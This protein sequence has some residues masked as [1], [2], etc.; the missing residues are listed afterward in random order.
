MSDTAEVVVIGAGVIGCAIAFEFARAGR[1]VVVLERAKGPGMGSTSASSAIIRFNYS[2]YTGVAAAWEARHSWEGWAA[3]L[4]GRD[5]GALARF[6][7]TGALFLDAEGFDNART[8][9]LFDRVGV[10]FERWSAE[11]LREHFPGIEP[12]RHH[13]PKP[14]DSEAFWD[15]PTGEL[16]GVFTPDAG[17]VD[18]PS[19]AAH[20]LM[21]AAQR[22]GADFR[23]GTPVVAV[24]SRGGRV[25]GVTLGDGSVLGCDVLI[26]VTGPNSGQVNELAG[27]LDDFRIRTRPLRQEVHELPGD[28]RD[29][30]LVA[31]L[32]LGT[33]FRSTPSGRLMIGGTDPECDPL[34]WLNHPDEY[35]ICATREQYQAHSYRVARRLPEIGIPPAVT[36]IAG[37]YD[38]STDWVPIYDRTSLD[39]FY[40]AV[41]TSGNQFKNAPVVGGIMAAIVTATESG[42]DH[43]TDPVQHLLPQTGLTINL[44]DYSRLRNP[45]ATAGNVMG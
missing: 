31:D 35:A 5:D 27:V 24:G 41:G 3:Y 11:Q 29:Y 40:V 43:D 10:P 38:V 26:N 45:A 44:G 13:P 36:G 21:V 15:P 19:F 20:N 32:D 8:C 4:G 37:V 14:V 23:F 30:P 7:R 39:G 9:T 33:Y 6:H 1:R 17:F 42:I 12:G 28:G 2:T 16:G 25:S 18:D 34:E 22:H